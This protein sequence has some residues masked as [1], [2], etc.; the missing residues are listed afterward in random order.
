MILI[1]IRCWYTLVSV[2]EL[3]IGGEL[4]TSS[5]V[6][7]EIT[8]VNAIAIV[9][10]LRYVFLTNTRSYISF[11]CTDRWTVIITLGAA[12]ACIRHDMHRIIYLEPS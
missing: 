10:E 6:K 2:L 9:Y 8:G 4:N 3:S 11:L 7:N 1:I 5:K 12:I